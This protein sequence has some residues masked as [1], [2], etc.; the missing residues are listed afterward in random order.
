MLLHTTVLV[1]PS[2]HTKLTD[3]ASAHRRVRA[4]EVQGIVTSQAGWHARGETM[5]KFFLKIT[6]FSSLYAASFA[7]QCEET[8]YYGGGYNMGQ[9]LE[10]T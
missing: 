4:V 5:P 6:L 8:P 7:V 10:E 3:V 2:H 9:H 1:R